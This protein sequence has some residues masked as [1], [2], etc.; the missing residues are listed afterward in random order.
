MRKAS[1][2]ISLLET[3]VAIILLALTVWSVQFLYVGL[4]RG[5]GLSDARRA[6]LASAESLQLIWREK[7]TETWPEEENLEDEAYT[8]E[9]E[10]GEYTYRVEVGPRIE[11]P[12]YDPSELGSSKVLEM[13][14]LKVVLLFE[15]Q[16]VERKIELVSS[17]SK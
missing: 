6:A 5:T 12:V 4:L 7:A 8:V 3:L 9:G 2:G 17:V 13:R 10:F 15:E 11:N 16:N 14:K 1:A